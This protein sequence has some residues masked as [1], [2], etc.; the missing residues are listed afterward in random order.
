MHHSS[1]TGSQSLPAFSASQASGAAAT[2]R[3]IC[4]APAATPAVD[5]ATAPRIPV[6][7]PCAPARGGQTKYFKCG[8]PKNQDHYGLSIFCTDKR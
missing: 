6:P 8:A 4:T 2:P 7:S 1:L 5:S 3:P